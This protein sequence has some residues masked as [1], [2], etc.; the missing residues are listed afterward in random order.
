MESHFFSCTLHVQPLRC[1]LVPETL[2]CDYPFVKPTF[3]PVLWLIYFPVTPS[4]YHT[5]YSIFS[6]YFHS[7]WTSTNS[8]FLWF[9]LTYSPLCLFQEHAPTRIIF[10]TK[11]IFLLL[12]FVHNKFPSIISFALCSMYTLDPILGFMCRF[13]NT[14]TPYHL[15]YHKSPLNPFNTETRF[16]IHCVY[17]LVILKS[18]RNSN[19][20]QN[21]TYSGH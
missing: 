18:F 11:S 6:H 5:V 21:S 10:F 3:Y 8:I 9:T 12:V 19:G 7:L 15:S 13:Q 2:L 14:C 1:F 16:Y 20:N 4:T 17:N